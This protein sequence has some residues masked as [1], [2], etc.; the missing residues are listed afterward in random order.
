MSR[1]LVS[2]AL[3]FLFTPGLTVAGPPPD[4]RG[5]SYDQ[6]PGNRLPLSAT[7]RDDNGKLVQLAALID[8]KPLILDLGYFHCPAL[9]GIVRADLLRA[10][11]RSNLVAGRD[12]TLVSLSIDPAET[13]QDAAAAKRGD[14]ARFRAAGA[15]Q[16]WHF[17]TGTAA[18]IKTIADAVGF[19]ER[20]DP[21]LKQFLHPTGIV[22][23]TPTGV[24]SNYLLGVGYQTNDIELAL[25][26]ARKGS[27]ASAALPVLLLCFD[28]DASTG[29]Y[30]LAILKLL[31]LGGAITVLTLGFTLWLAFRRDR[32][33]A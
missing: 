20:F 16:G 28:Y 23:A 2:A 8:G 31:R 9:C 15:D 13:P 19:R 11:T 10:L 33:P 29:R 30:T 3:L 6:R 27:I 22:F 4:L 18:A 32:S 21:Q 26:R 25:T 1:F 17:M 5:I 14:L 12:Y 7:L 24:I